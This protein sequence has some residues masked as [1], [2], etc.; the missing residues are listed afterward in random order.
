M[1]GASGKVHAPIR[2]EGLTAIF[3]GCEPKVDYQTGEVRIDRESGLPLYFVY[4]MV[5]LPG[6][7]R[8]QVW[9]VTVVGEPKGIQ[10]GQ[11]VGISDDMVA[12]EWEMEGGTHGISFRASSIFPLNASGRNGSAKAEAAAA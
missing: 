5:V 9:R 3:S 7:V 1:A 6:E 4:L 8:P 12:S 10:P 11:A 2:T